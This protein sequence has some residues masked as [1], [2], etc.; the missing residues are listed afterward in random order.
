LAF[1][2]QFRFAALEWVKPEQAATTASVV[3]M[4]GLVAAWVGPEMVMLGKELFTH[5][6]SGVFVLLAI[7]HSLLLLLLNFIPF[8]KSQYNEQAD[9]GR[10]LKT[11]LATPAIG[12][13]VASGA[14]AYGV[15]SLIMTATPVSM[16]EIQNFPLQETKTVIQSHIMAMFLPSLITPLLIR[17]LSISGVLLL[18]VLSMVLAISIAMFDQS[19]WGYWAALVLLGLGWNFL[20]VGGT[21]LLMQS[22]QPQEGFRVQAVNEVLVFSTQAMMSLLAGWLVFSYGWFVVNLLAIPLLILTLIMLSRW[23]LANTKQLRDQ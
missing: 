22:Y 1:V 19:Y 20:F 12:A 4:G 17:R 21:I 9:S 11:L 3:L 13:A 14:V 15:M 7:S 2:Q 5:T 16:T 6:F 23:Y 18:G 8:A 10:P